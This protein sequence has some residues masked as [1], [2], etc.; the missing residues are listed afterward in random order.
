MQDGDFVGG[1]EVI[2]EVLK[3]GMETADSPDGLRLELVPDGRSA[4]PSIAITTRRWVRDGA[5]ELWKLPVPEWDG[6][7]IKHGKL[8]CNASRASATT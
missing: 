3:L 1:H 4:N 5:E 7:L 2:S 8:I 6:S